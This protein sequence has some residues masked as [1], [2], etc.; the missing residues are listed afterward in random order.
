[1]SFLVSNVE[2][3]QFVNA[4]IFR[5][6]DAFEEFFWLIEQSAPVFHAVI[7]EV[8]GATTLEQWED[9]L[10][11]IQIRY[12]LLSASIR[13][14]PGKR[15]FFE[16]ERG[17]SMP[18]R[19][20]P[21]TDSLTLEEEMEKA[22]QESFGDGS[23]PLTRATL[24]HAR[25]RSVIMFATHHGSMDGKS[26]LVLVQDLLASVAGE[27]LGEPL[28]VQPGLGHLLGMPA[29][30]EYVKKLDGRSVAPEA[31]THVEMPRV[32]VRRLQLGVKETDRLL[33]RA[34][35][36][37]TSVH[38]AL[39]ATLTL[40][41]K[42]R[43]E[44]NSGPVRCV[45]AIDMRRTLGIP[46]AVGVLI[47]SHHAPVLA[48]EEASFWDIARKVRE[49]MLPAQSAD[50]ARQLLG[51]LSSM[52]A[53][54]HNAQDLY[55]S[56]LEGPFM[57][58]LMVSNYAGYQV[59]AEYENLKI[60]NLFTGSP[61]ITSARQKVSVLTLNGRLGMTL[62]ARDVFPTLLEDARQILAR[63]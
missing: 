2:Q 46:D 5:E 34:K 11:A 58:E 63:V 21:L 6:L 41:G 52:V 9:A 18:L 57:R 60:E 47:S 55:R 19:I 33:A 38:A 4:T 20:E 49:D 17:A 26:H 7:A 13:K 24:F 37:N 25:D 39:V 8:N 16:K 28:E 29:P 42:R 54:E 51:R 36:E 62:V 53:E 30:A 61:S 23:G 10:D 31:G 14:S 48:P 59:R 1:M 44:W 45:S 40:A 50:G 3:A 22:L 27:D 12:P 32:Q 35:E 15:P 43:S 56:V